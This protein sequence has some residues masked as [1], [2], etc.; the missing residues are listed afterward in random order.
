M[1]LIFILQT[2]QDYRQKYPK[3]TLNILKK[4]F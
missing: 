2:I 1:F 3:P 4:S